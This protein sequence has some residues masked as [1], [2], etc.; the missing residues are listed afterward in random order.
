M[1]KILIATGGTGGH[2]YPAVV[3]AQELRRRGCQ[4]VFIGTFGAAEEKIKD[5]GFDRVAIVSEGFVSRGILQKIAAVGAMVMAFGRCVQCMR[6]LRPDI[7]LGFGGY[8]S[9]PTVLA[10]FCCGVPAIVHEQNALPGQANKLLG[11]LVRR[12]A[13][14][15]KDAAGFF[16]KGKAVWTGNPLRPFDMLMSREQAHV[17]LGL[18][19]LKCTVLIFGGSQGSRA[20]NAHVVEVFSDI[21]QGVDVQVI[22]I[23]GKKDFEQVKDRYRMLGVSALVR[24]YMERIAVAYAA[25]DLVIGRSGAGTVTELGLLGVAA[26]LI[27][28][29]G[30]RDHQKYNARVLERLGTASIIEEKCL[31]QDILRDKIFS[32][33][34]R[35]PSGIL[36]AKNR[37]ILKNDFIVDGAERLCDEVLKLAHAC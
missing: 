22:H 24:E 7:V 34:R 28:Y 35:D 2:V 18:D 5:A 17:E 21:P 25:A 36:R 26:V 30:A 13:V 20:I 1:T 8:S 12:A 33:L 37:D 6:S 29:P 19:V 11:M 23:T 10:A 4:V 32:Q 31:R 3:T 27:P 14:G 15:F 9:F 16:P